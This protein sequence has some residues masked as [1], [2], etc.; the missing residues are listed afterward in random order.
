MVKRFAQGICVVAC[1][2]MT[3][4]ATSNGGFKYIKP[5]RQ[6]VLT[7]NT[8]KQIIEHNEF[9]EKQRNCTNP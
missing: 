9:C 1:L 2:V 3:G 5:S 8:K 4:C 6:D 7:E